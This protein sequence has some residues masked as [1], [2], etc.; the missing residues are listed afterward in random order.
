MNE[1]GVPVRVY[2]VLEKLVACPCSTDQPIRRSVNALPPFRR[3]LYLFIVHLNFLSSSAL[4]TSIIPFA[5][6]QESPRRFQTFMSVERKGSA[7]KP[8]AFPVSHC[9]KSSGLVSHKTTS[10]SR[11]TPPPLGLPHPGKLYLLAGELFVSNASS[12]GSMPSRK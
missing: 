1:D 8:H 12:L 2:L 3:L 4:L 6:T 5:S 9:L 10:R 7:Y 11:Y